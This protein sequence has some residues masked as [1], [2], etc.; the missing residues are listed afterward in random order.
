MLWVSVT[1]ED[2][3][4]LER[5]AILCEQGEHQNRLAFKIVDHVT[6]RFDSVDPAS[7]ETR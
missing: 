3:E 6:N 5:V 1:T 4:L 2:G 7:K